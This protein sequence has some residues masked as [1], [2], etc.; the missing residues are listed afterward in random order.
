[1]EQL[2]RFLQR[3][4]R[5]S[6]LVLVGVRVEKDRTDVV[7]LIP[8]L[9]RL[10]RARGLFATSYQRLDLAL[11]VLSLPTLSPSAFSSPH[12]VNYSLESIL[13][14]INWSKVIALPIQPWNRVVPAL[15]ALLYASA[16]LAPVYSASY[17]LSQSMEVHAEARHVRH[18]LDAV[19]FPDTLVAGTAYVG[20]IHPPDGVLSDSPAFFSRFLVYSRGC[21]S[22][23]PSF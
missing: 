17:F 12:H 20:D 5:Y 4:T 18:L 14:G 10:Q 8:F 15:N 1:M 11:A 3:A 6:Q 7:S 9:Q 21:A 23:C 13:T 16:V 22:P 2:L 19:T